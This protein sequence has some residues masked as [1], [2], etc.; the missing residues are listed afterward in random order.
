MSEQSAIAFRKLVSAMRTSQKK[1]WDTRSKYALKQSIELE[2][3][4]DE[5]IARVGTDNVPDNDNGKFFL[6]VARCRA[7]TKDYFTQKKANTPDK[8][9]IKVLFKEVKDQESKIDQSLEQWNDETARKEGK[10]IV[11]HVMERMPKAKEAKSVFDTPD[12]QEAKIYL[13]DYYRTQPIP[14]AFYYICKEYKERA[15][16]PTTQQQDQQPIKQQDNGKEQGK[17]RN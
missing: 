14:G 4:V 3:R 16:Q 5:I 17:Q 2:K 12:E 6:S 7:S 10:A 11:W 15:K 1:Y 13:N 8:E 9:R